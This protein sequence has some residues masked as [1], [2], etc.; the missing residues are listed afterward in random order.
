[1]LGKFAAIIGPL[2]MGIVTLVTGNVRS[3]IISL[4]A[5][6]ALGFILLKRVDERKGQE[7]IKSFMENQ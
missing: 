4:V 7:E 1:M 5:L 2:L 3:G 6:F